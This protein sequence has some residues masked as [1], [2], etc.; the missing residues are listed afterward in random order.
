[1]KSK[2]NKSTSQVALAVGGVARVAEA[3]VEAAKT[4]FG[5][6]IDRPAPQGG[7]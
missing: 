7:S 4:V 3:A 6:R 2:N 5:S 1:M